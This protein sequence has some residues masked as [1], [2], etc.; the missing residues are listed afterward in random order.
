MLLNGEE[1]R[2]IRQKPWWMYCIPWLMGNTC[3]ALY[4]HFYVSK[5][6]YKDLTSKS[7]SPKSVAVALHELEHLKR[8]HT[9]G[10]FKYYA[11]YLLSRRFRF[12]EEMACKAIEIRYLRERGETL[13]LERVSRILS[14]WAYL[15]CTSY[16]EALKRL[17]A[18]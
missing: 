15:W 8:A 5:R 14:G 3:V 7:P 1:V 4:P 16:A 12:E 13:D 10:V 9:F 17:Q 2:N 18:I 11:L 6:I